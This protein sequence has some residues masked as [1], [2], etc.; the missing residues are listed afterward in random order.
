MQTKF[1]AF[2]RTASIAKA[3]TNLEI[4]SLSSVRQ[5]LEGGEP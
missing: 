3:I 2:H 5:F 4:F 1:A